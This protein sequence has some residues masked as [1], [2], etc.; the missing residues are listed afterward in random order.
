MASKLSRTALTL[1][2]RLTTREWPRMPASYLESAAIGVFAR[3]VASMACTSPGQGFP[4]S[5]RVASGVTSR[6]ENPVPPVVR[7]RRGRGLQPPPPADWGESQNARI[8]AEMAALSSGTTW[9]THSPPDATMPAV[10][11][12]PPAT[13]RPCNADTIAGPD[14]S[15]AVPA[16]QESETVSTITSTSR[17]AA[18]PLAGLWLCAASAEPAAEASVA[19]PDPDAGATWLAAGAALQPHA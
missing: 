12:G 16:A 19:R 17:F 10:A 1:P 6:P 9:A 4:K 2:G 5:G 13:A 7:T 11:A 8:A 18:L 3:P 15:T 14:R